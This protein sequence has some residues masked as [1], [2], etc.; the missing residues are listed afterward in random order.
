MLPGHEPTQHRCQRT[1]VILPG[2]WVTNTVPEPEAPSSRV[3]P[4]MPTCKHRCL[5]GRPGN[6]GL[7]LAVKETSAW[8]PLP[9][10][11]VQGPG[12]TVGGSPLTLPSSA[13]APARAQRLPGAGVTG[14]HREDTGCTPFIGM[15]MVTVHPNSQGSL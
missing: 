15:G 5:A 8:G 7:C 6:S 9:A 12:L 4:G 10:W 11:Q 14:G 2:S 1:R 3:W 13:S